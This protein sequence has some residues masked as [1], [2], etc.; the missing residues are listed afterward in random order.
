MAALELPGPL[1]DAH[2]LRK[3]LDASDLVIFDASWHMPQTGRDAYREWREE[4]IPGARFFDFDGRIK[5]PD[6]DLPHMLPNAEIFTREV[7]ALGLNEDSRVVLYDT[8]GVFSCARGWWMLRAMG[9]RHCALLDGGLPAWEEADY[10]VAG[11]ADESEPAWPPGDFVARL[12]PAL[13]AEAAAVA[14][15]LA[16]PSVA[17]IDARPAPRFSGAAEE[18]RPGLRRGHMPGAVNLPFPELFDQGRLKPRAELRRL[19]APVLDG[20]ERAIYSCGSGVTAC[21]LAFAA[22]C[23]GYEGY[24]V[25]DGSWSEWG[26]PGELPVVSD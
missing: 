11:H 24:A 14:A 10:P 8:M 26:L 12:D 13:L 17:V 7:R 16:D 20:R 3:N 6:S 15:A 25:Y 18:P 2:W 4:H 9:C 22:H 21:I 5:D 23:C 1:V 19:L